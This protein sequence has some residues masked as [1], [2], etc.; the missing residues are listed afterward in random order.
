MTSAPI[1]PER[2]EWTVDDLAQLP[3]DLRYELING[4]LIS[5]P[6]AVGLHNWICRHI[7]K[8]WRTSVLLN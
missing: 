1:L 6:S 8:P 2:A 3:P 5:L 4:S 7:A